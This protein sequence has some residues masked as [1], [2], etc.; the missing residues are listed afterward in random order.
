MASQPSNHHVTEGTERRSKLARRLPDDIWVEFEP[1]LPAKVWAGVGRHRR[2]TGTAPTPSVHPTYYLCDQGQKE[3]RE[4]FHLDAVVI[5]A[6][7]AGLLERRNA[8]TD[9]IIVITRPKTP[10]SAS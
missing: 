5:R 9:S 2:P 10:T 4:E 7:T 1:I 6:G 3:L 8:G